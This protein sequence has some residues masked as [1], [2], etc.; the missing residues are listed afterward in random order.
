LHWD[1]SEDL[2]Q[3]KVPTLVI[4][5]QF[6]TMDPDYMS[7]MAVKIPN[8]HFLYCMNGSHL[9]MWD[10]QA[11]YFAGLDRF[12]KDTDEGK[13]WRKGKVEYFDKE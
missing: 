10:D 7:W 3:I 2:D 9:A 4:G 13:M 1:R 12:I 6:D 5:A 8:G 11:A